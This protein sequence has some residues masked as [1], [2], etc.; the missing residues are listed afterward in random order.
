MK[1]FTG[2][3]CPGCG[4]TRAA[5]AL[6]RLDPMHAITHYPLPALIWMLFIVG[7]LWAGWR[8]WRRRPLPKL[9]RRLPIGVRLGLLGVVLANWAYSIATGV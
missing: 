3:P 2:I 6:A 7:G 9:P 5:L 1:S 8:G 4:T